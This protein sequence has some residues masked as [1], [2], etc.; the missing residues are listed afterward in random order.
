MV[1]NSIFVGHSTK[2]IRQSKKRG[3]LTKL[4]NPLISEKDIFAGLI[5]T[6]RSYITFLQRSKGSDLDATR[7]NKRPIFSAKLPCCSA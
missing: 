4:S 6:C 2:I 1:Q 5:E 7:A 3:P